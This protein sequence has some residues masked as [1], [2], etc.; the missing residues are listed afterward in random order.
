MGTTQPIRNMEQLKKLENFYYDREPNLRNY[1]LICL[2]INSALRI[3]DLLHL[4]WKD[5]YEFSSGEF[6][7]HIILTEQKTQ[8]ETRIALNKS[9][10]NALAQYM[11]SLPEVAPDMYIFPGKSGAISMLSRSQAFRII[12]HASEQ[13]HLGSGISCHSMRKTFG[14]HA[15]RQGVSPV[16]LMEIY[17]HSSYQITK[18]Y[19]GIEQEDKDSVFLN[20]NL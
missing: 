6:C 18:R 16:I 5:V 4:K 1:A 15:W 19:L 10:R 7:Y 13:L 8:K 2:G 9:A 11:H 20:M 14:Y 12:R 3:S 17:N